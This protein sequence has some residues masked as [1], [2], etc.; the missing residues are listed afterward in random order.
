MPFPYVID[1]QRRF[2]RITLSGRVSGD[3]IADTMRSL[4]LDPEWQYGF[5]TLWDGRRITELLFAHDDLKKFAELQFELV[6]HAGP[7]VDV[8]LMTRELDR[9]TAEAY[10]KFAE[11]S[12]RHAVVCSTESEALA[13]LASHSEPD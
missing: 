5:N 4:Y 9:V 1:S 7:G 11:K 12:T 10:A 13:I 6:D 3:A 2:S 8:L